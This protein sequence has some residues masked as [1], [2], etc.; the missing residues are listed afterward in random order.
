MFVCF[1]ADEMGLEGWVTIS[2]SPVVLRVFHDACLPFSGHPLEGLEKDADRKD[3]PM[4]RRQQQ[5]I[6][7][8]PS[9]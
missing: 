2:A 4:T 5:R 6:G 8:G 7:W 1:E 9:L 3:E